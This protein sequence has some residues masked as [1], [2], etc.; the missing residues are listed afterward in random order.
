MVMAFL[1]LSGS[2]TIFPIGGKNMTKIGDKI[3]IIQ[4][5]GE[6]KYEGGKALSN[7]SMTLASSTAPGAA[8][9]SSLERINSSL[10]KEAI[11][12]EKGEMAFPLQPEE[13]NR[14]DG[15][16]ETPLPHRRRD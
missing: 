7:T 11:R 13:K 5:E 12:Y 15:E 14:W 4:M 2:T 1:T 9:R 8:A 3:K 10:S 6:P 16:G